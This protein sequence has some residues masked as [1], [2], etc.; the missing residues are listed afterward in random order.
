VQA[1]CRDLGQLCQSLLDLF[2]LHFIV[3]QLFSEVAIVG[4]E[5]K[6]AVTTVV[7]EDHFGLSRFLAGQGLIVDGSDRMGRLGGNDKAFSLSKAHSRFEAGILVV[8][9][10]FRLSLLQEGTDAGCHAVVAQ[11][12]CVNRGRDEIVAAVPA[13]AQDA[14]QTPG[15]IVD[16]A[17]ND[18]RFNTLV[19]AVTAADLLLGFPADINVGLPQ[20]LMF[21][22]AMG[23]I[24]QLSLHI[25][26]FALILPIAAS[27]FRSWPVERRIWLAMGLAATVE[28]GF[29][30][31][32]ALS[33]ALNL[34]VAM[35]LILFGIVELVLY[36]RYDYL[37]MYLFRLT[38]Y[39][40]WHILWG[41]LRLL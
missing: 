9:A 20:A 41:Y 1:L 8:G 35:Q 26:P 3:R 6:V 40:Y 25:I 13:F 5:I 36:R 23:Y 37:S 31:H 29:Q 21:Y 7:E 10:G 24:A 30:V 2:L 19:A 14:E 11:A 12:A 28:A 18:G 17:V 32:A 22:P 16:I 38:Y 33:E 39:G 15:S 27:I 34:F 4:C